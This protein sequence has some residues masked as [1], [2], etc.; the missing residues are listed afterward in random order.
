M[1]N[2]FV[3]DIAQAKTLFPDFKLKNRSPITIKHQGS[4]YTYLGSVKS[5]IRGCCASKFMRA[6]QFILL[7]SLSIFGFV[8][9][10]KPYRKLIANKWSE[11]RTGQEKVKIFALNTLKQDCSNH[12]QKPNTTQEVAMGDIQLTLENIKLKSKIVDVHDKPVPFNIKVDTRWKNFDNTEKYLIPKKTGLILGYV[13]LKAEAKNLRINEI[14]DYYFET[15]KDYKGIREALIEI[16]IRKSIERNLHL[17]VRTD[18]VNKADVYKQSGFQS[19]ANSHSTAR[20]KSSKSINQEGFEDM[21]LS[22]K[23]L[24]NWTKIIKEEKKSLSS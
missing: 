20:N 24:D 8:L 15:F 4:N 3:P 22:K 1:R 2:E 18:Q 11:C 10:I 5:S 6:I 16:A 17:I 21:E 23:A 12:S 9:A 13:I 7:T 14:V 19:N